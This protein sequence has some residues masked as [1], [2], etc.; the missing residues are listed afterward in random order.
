MGRA[1]S[2]RPGRASVGH[3]NVAGVGEALEATHWDLLTAIDE[4]LLP[5]PDARQPG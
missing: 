3:G 2:R 4:I 5:N 1:G